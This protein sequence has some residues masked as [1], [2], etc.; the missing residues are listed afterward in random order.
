MK[1]NNKKRIFG[2]VIISVLLSVLIIANWFLINEKLDV[3]EAR[4]AV[5]EKVIYDVFNGEEE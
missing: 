4:L 3:T 1:Y 5:L 2:T